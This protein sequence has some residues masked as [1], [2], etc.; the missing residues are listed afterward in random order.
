MYSSMENVMGEAKDLFQLGVVYL[1]QR[2]HDEAEESFAQ[3][4]VAFASIGNVAFEARALDGLMGIYV[5]QRKFEDA[6]VAW[7]PEELVSAGGYEAGVKDLI[8]Q[9]SGGSPK[10]ITE[11]LSRVRD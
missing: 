11:S 6:K 5:L 3:A 2:R 4:R 7:R 10:K 8:N 1:K 9:E